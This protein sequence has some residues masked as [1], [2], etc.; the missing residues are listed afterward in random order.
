MDKNTLFNRVYD[1]LVSI[2]G[3]SETERRGFLYS[4]TEDKFGC[5]EWRFCGH[6][7]FGGKFRSRRFTVDCYRESETPE[8]LRIIAELNTALEV[9]KPN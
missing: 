8:R 3:A 6:L 4:H 2:G 9:L 7:G 5:D 1:L